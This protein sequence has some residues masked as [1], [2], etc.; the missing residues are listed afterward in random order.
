M[1]SK[2]KTLPPVHPGEILREDFMVDYNLK[3]KRLAELMDVPRS[4]IEAII[5][6]ERSITA[7]TAIRLSKVFKWPAEMWLNIQNK[8]DIQ[9]ALLNQSDSYDKIKK[10]A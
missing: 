4:R 2:I 10:F 5:R 3:S 8:H 1:M 9:Q 7:D 6:C